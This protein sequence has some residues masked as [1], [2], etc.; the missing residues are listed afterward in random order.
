MSCPVNMGWKG[1]GWAFPRLPAWGPSPTGPLTL[2]AHQHHGHL[3][4][5]AEAAEAQ[6]VVVHCLEADLI[7]QAEDKYNSVHPHGKLGREE[8]GQS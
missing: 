5:V 4:G 6:E 8:G 2:R 1:R 7:L 3:A